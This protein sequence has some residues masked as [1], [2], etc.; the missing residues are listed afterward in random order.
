MSSN[1]T[2]HEP[3]PEYLNSS[4]TPTSSNASYD[5]STDEPAFTGC[6]WNQPVVVDQAVKSQAL[7]CY[8]AFATWADGVNLALSTI[9]KSTLTYFT[10]SW[11]TTSDYPWP[12]NLLY[13]TL[14]DGSHRVD[15]VP[16]APRT[17]WSSSTD[18]AWQ[19]V[20]PPRPC[21]VPAEGC[22]ALYYNSTIPPTDDHLNALCGFPAHLCSPCL[23]KGG[24]IRLL[25][26]PVT[27]VGGDKCGKTGTTLS[28]TITAA[29]TVQTLGT[30]LTSG[31]VYLSFKTLYASWDGFG[32]TYGNTY[33][34]LILPFSS[35]D[36][37]TYCTGKTEGETV[38][39]DL[40]RRLN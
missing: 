34:N 10:S 36:I 18:S 26:F 35:S 15:F 19:P 20:V 8:S 2:D 5:T 23:I 9:T 27:T 39:I 33:S 31:T 7:A 13:Y 25:Y 1:P 32:N 37:S 30:T 16:P 17:I 24:P 21:S 22:E 4:A 40:Y 38:H 11:S 29:P 12:N 3:C 6:G 14:C 28:P